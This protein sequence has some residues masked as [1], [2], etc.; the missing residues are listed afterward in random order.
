MPTVSLGTSKMRRH[1]GPDRIVVDNNY[2]PRGTKDQKDTANRLRAKCVEMD[3]MENGLREQIDECNDCHQSLE[4]YHQLDETN[5]LVKQAYDTD[6]AHRI[7]MNNE[8]VE[9]RLRETLTYE[10]PILAVS[11]I[12]YETQLAGCLPRDAPALS[13]E[14]TNIPKLRRLI[15]TSPSEIRLGE[16]RQLVEV[17]MP[18]QLDGL[19]AFVLQGGTHDRLRSDLVKILP[20]AR[21]MLDGPV[22]SAFDALCRDFQ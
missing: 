14:E 19:D 4:L 9:A 20:Q 22:R 21:A 15:A 16:V 8:R 10:G 17:V 13:V 2:P 12:E 1:L 18:A 6:K 3:A 7:K 11:N 5:P